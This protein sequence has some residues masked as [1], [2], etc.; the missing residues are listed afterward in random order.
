VGLLLGLIAIYLVMENRELLLGRAVPDEVEQRFVEV[1]RA[2]TSIAD[3]H[4]VKTRQLTPETFTFKAEIRFSEAFVAAKLAEAI[5]AEALARGGEVR[6]SM[7]QDAARHIIRA[8]SEE[9]DAIEA[10]VRAAIP[11]AKH[12]DLELEHLPVPSTEQAPRPD[13][14]KVG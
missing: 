1:V 10:E 4:D 12:I 13:A 6:E 14:Q 7:L 11:E 9:V 2:R 8:L 3:I 5:P